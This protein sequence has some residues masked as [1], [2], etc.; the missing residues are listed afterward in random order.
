M[1]KKFQKKK[2]KQIHYKVKSFKMLKQKMKNINY[3]KKSKK[4]K[5]FI[6]KFLF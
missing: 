6:S 1:L 5:K 3:K 2:S 4:L